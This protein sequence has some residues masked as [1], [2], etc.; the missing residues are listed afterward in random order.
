MDDWINKMWCIYPMGYYL[1][2]KRNI[3]SYATPCMK[4]EGILR[5][6]ISQTQKAKYSCPSVSAG[7]CLQDLPGTTKSGD[8]QVQ[9]SAI[10]IQGSATMD[11]A[12]HGSCSTVL[13]TEE[14]SKY[15]WTGA[16]Q[17]HVVQGPTMQFHIH[18]VR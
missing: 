16:F 18:K 3:L 7:D 14:N 12:N 10:W 15:K 6:E 11:S 5:Y 17:T 2:L 8:V 9:E 1:A 4:L 13:F